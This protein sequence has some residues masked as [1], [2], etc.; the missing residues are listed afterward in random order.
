[1]D[2][3]LEKGGVGWDG[4]RPVLIDRRRLKEEKELVALIH[5][6]LMY[7]FI[8][9]ILFFPKCPSSPSPNL[10]QLCYVSNRERIAFSSY[11]A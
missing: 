10:N 9:V 2:A 7:Y 4:G 11:Y 1:M 6:M 8:S 5:L 3:F